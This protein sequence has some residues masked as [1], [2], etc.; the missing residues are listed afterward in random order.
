LYAKLGRDISLRRQAA[1]N[2]ADF[3]DKAREFNLPIIFIKLNHSEW[4]ES[5]SWLR[6]SQLRGPWTTAYKEGTWG[7]E[8]YAVQPKQGDAVVTKH[9][10]SAFV[11][12][13][14]E[15]ILGS[16]K[17]A[18]L[19]VTGGGTAACVESTVRHGLC[20]DYDI[21]VISDCCGSS[22]LNEHGPALKRMEGLGATVVESWQVLEAL[23]QLRN[24]R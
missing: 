11:G 23:K 12:T 13:D 2:A 7:E 18:T 3:I 20:L 1:H 22:T 21:V 24:A 9:R 6:R 15:M 8:F 17:I 5:S 10:Y 19:L 14:L 4:N 16:R